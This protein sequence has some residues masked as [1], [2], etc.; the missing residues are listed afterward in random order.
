MRTREHLLQLPSRSTPGVDLFNRPFGIFD[1]SHLLKSAVVWGPVGAEAV[2]AQLF[3]EEKS[4]FFKE[5]D[6][7][8]ARQEGINY[9]ET[10][11]SWGVEVISARDHLAKIL[12]RVNLEVTLDKRKVESELLS[13]SRAIRMVFGGPNR[14]LGGTIVHLLEEDI[15]LYGERD[16]L[17]LNH[18]LCRTER[19][20][21]GNLLYARDQMNV[22]LGQR[23]VSSMA[24][25]IRKPEVLLYEQV[26]NAHLVDHEPIK[27][28]S[29]ETF[30]G[31]DAYIH[32]GHVWVGVGTR[33]TMGAALKI[34]E[35]LKGD[36]RRH[37]LKFAV[38][39]DEDAFNRP[40]SEQQAFM[41][42]DT[43]SNPT[44]K[45]D[46]AVCLEEATRRKILLVGSIGES[47]VIKDTRLS[48]IDYLEH[49]VKEDNIVVISKGEQQDFGCNFL[50]LGEYDD[51]RTVILVPLQSNTD[52]NNQLRRLGKE[53]VLTDLYQS[54]RGYGAAHCMTGQLLRE[55]A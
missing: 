31:G 15:K 1:E 49:E 43:F 9:Q 3:P 23:V 11:R 7:P 50:L 55:V 51:G 45:K 20:P 38:V 12:G 36:L 41:H 30:E 44:G 42:L 35:G 8:A 39:R 4:L 19:L 29:G 2:L 53:V 16:A 10:L 18:I 27:I 37:D 21:L 47:T 28:P 48:F 46:I 54:T 52:T 34:Y 32:Q 24:K 33:T 14:G 17:A 22:L 6:V 40:F 13:Q 25:E 26:Y 5:F